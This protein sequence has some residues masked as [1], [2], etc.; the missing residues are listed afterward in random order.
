MPPVAI[1]AWNAQG[2][3]PPIDVIDPVSAN[4]SPYP[5]TLSEVVLRFG[6]SPE[7]C[8]ILTGLLNY[9]AA[10][11]ALGLTRGFQWLDGSFLEHIEV[12]ESRPPNDIDVVTFFHLPTDQTQNTVAARNPRLFNNP[13]TKANF[14]VDSYVV[15]LGKQPEYVVDA[16]AYWYSVWSHRRNQAWKGYA[17][18]DLSPAADATALG[19][20]QTISNTGGQP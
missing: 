11:Y 17:Q 5:V 2:L 20:L 8:E 15:D 6:I 13:W 1:P 10:L 7:R 16:S 19:L 12:I 18:V 14:H 3:I 4:R 9:R